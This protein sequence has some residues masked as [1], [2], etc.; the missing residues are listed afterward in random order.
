MIHVAVISPIYGMYPP[1][2]VQS[3]FKIIG[4]KIH[5]TEQVISFSIISPSENSNITII[6]NAC[7]QQLLNDE[8]ELG[9]KFDYI[10][11]IDCDISFTIDD[12]RKLFVS[13]KDIVSGLYFE[14]KF[15][16]RPVAGFYE[17]NDKKLGFPRI[18]DIHGEK[19]IEVDWIGMGFVLIKREILSSIESDYPWFEMKIID[20]GDKKEILSEDI[21][22]WLKIR[23]KKNQIFVN[24]SV[25]VKHI[26]KYLYSYED[27]LRAYDLNFYNR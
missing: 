15:P 5:F 18:E 26:G 20:I 2:W 27:Y 10:L 22:F 7:L 13:K 9:I 19:L 11:F 25:K 21:S 1:E 24:T 4:S 8:K 16:F 23:E 12:F 3:I 6:R 14:K 17:I